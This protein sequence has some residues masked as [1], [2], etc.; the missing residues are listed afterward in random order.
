MRRYYLCRVVGAGTFADRFRS[1]ALDLIAG[2]KRQDTSS[3]FRSPVTAGDWCISAVDTEDHA[4]LLAD[5]DVK[6]LPDL[7]LDDPLGA[8]PAAQATLAAHLRAVG[9]DA[10]GL[11]GN[12]PYRL[13]LRRAGRAIDPVFDEDAFG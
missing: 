8:A 13:A 10:A 9:I 6:A 12:E 2:N 5:P 7:A 3:R 11:R 1:K 4:R